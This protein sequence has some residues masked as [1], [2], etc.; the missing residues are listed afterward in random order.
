MSICSGG[1]S[2]MKFLVPGGI[3][4]CLCRTRNYLLTPARETCRAELPGAGIP[5]HPANWSQW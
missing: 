5:A 2:S 1:G 3:P 4:P